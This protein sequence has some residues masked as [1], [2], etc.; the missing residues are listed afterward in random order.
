MSL[1]QLQI[2]NGLKALQPVAIAMAVG[3]AFLLYTTGAPFRNINATK[4]AAY[5]LIGVGS[6]AAVVDYG[7]VNFL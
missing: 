7:V 2:K 1:S 5:A 6:A 3:G 4:V